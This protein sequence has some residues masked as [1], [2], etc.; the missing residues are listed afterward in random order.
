VA[1]VDNAACKG[2]GSY[3]RERGIKVELS[4]IENPRHNS[5]QQKTY[6]QGLSGGVFL[7]RGLYSRE[8]ANADHDDS[9]DYNPMHWQMHQ[10]RGVSESSDHDCESGSINS[11]RHTISLPSQRR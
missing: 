7:A 10:V 2:I 5:R 1:K 11:K 6:E 3:R 9:A 8:K 4:G